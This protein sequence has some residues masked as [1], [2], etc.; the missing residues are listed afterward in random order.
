MVARRLQ[1]KSKQHLV[2]VKSID[3]NFSIYIFGNLW[4][5]NN[6]ELTAEGCYFAIENFFQQSKQQVT[7][8]NKLEEIAYKWK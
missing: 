8:S 3:I 6:C 1:T 7:I 5:V 2:H 4:K